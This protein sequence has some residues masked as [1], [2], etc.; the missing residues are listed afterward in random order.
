MFE[1]S[2]RS[3]NRERIQDEDKFKERTIEHLQVLMNS[4]KLELKLK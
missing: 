2:S 1:M 4:I 3:E